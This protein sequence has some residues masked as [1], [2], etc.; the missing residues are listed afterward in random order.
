MFLNPPGFSSTKHLTLYSLGWTHWNSAT[1]SFVIEA[2]LYIC[3][4]APKISKAPWTPWV[5]FSHHSHRNLPWQLLSPESQKESPLIHSCSTPVQFHYLENQQWSFTDQGWTQEVPGILEYVIRSVTNVCVALIIFISQINSLQN[6]Q[7][8]T[9]QQDF[10]NVTQ[11]TEL[12][13]TL[14]KLLSQPG[15]LP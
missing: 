3:I 14:A 4:H 7:V 6:N 13:A 5:G 8:L 11:V 12:F 2:F 1:V 15:H 10:G 9:D